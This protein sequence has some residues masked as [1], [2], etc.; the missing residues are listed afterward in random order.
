[1]KNKYVFSLMTMIIFCCLLTQM[2]VADAI[3]INSE[4]TLPYKISEDLLGAM[5]TAGDDELIPVY[6]W[7]NDIDQE[8]AEKIT[9]N[10]IGYS[11]EEIV[12]KAE[13][14]ASEEVLTEISAMRQ[15]NMT[16]NE[17]I[18]RYLD[19]TKDIRAK[20]AEYTDLYITT[21]RNTEKSLYQ[22]ASDSLIT[23]MNIGEENTIFKSKFAPMLI[24]KLNKEKIMEISRDKEI[25]SLSLFKKYTIV[26]CSTTQQWEN[27]KETTNI[28]KTQ[29]IAIYKSPTQNVNLSGEGVSVGIVESTNM[30]LSSTLPDYPLSRFFIVGNYYCNNNTDTNH[31]NNSAKIFCSEY[32]IAYAATCYSSAIELAAGD[33]YMGDQS[34]FAAVETLLECNQTNP[35]KIINC[36]F[37]VLTDNEAYTSADKWVDHVVS[38]HNVSFVVSAGNHS[39]AHQ[40]Y[41]VTTPG[42]AYN[43]ITVGAYN[44][45]ETYSKEDDILWSNSCYNESGGCAKPDIVAPHNMFGGGTSSSAPYVSGVVALMIQARPSLAAYPDIIKAAILASCHNDVG[46][47]PNVVYDDLTPTGILDKQ[48]AGAVDPFRAVCIVCNGNYGFHWMAQ[49][50]TSS[51][52][53]IRQPQYDSTGINFSVVWPRTNTIN[54]NDHVTGSLT[55]GTLQNLALTIKDGSTVLGTSNLSNSSTE[56]VYTSTFPTS[57]KFTLQVTRSTNTSQTVRFTYAWSISN[58]RY[59]YARINEGV[60]TMRQKNTSLYLDVDSSHLPKLNTFSSATNKLWVLNRAG[61][62][63]YLP[64]ANAQTYSYLAVGSHIA[65]STDYNATVSTASS[66]LYSMIQKSDGSFMIRKNISSL[67]YMLDIKNDNAV[68]GTQAVWSPSDMNDSHQRWFIEKYAYQRGDV[69]MDGQVMADDAQFVLQIAVNSVT[70]TAAQLYLADCNGDEQIT[71][72]DA[73]IALRIATGLE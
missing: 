52:I 39:T 20:E 13:Q 50:Q 58:E 44:N 24:L 48:G 16:T 65:S 33:H 63:V 3:I 26:D 1:M 22:S 27:V 59:Q 72:D 5:I 10:K 37:S 73:R 32:G 57:H 56:M 14:S 49:N 12:A 43:A 67:A 54:G 55:V 30:Y 51:S 46:E 71:A 18:N 40:S 61:A 7:Y 25:S 23:K 66:T 8:E 19:V 6:L 42:K 60:F 31:A 62:N 45:S 35:V 47:D 38:T 21:K 4:K 34:L 68:S 36:S 15:A 17:E 64:H 28:N 11:K 70:P 29:D 2:I 41:C 69:N 53:S 9:E